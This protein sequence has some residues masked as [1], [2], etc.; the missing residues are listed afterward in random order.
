IVSQFARGL[1]AIDSPRER[2]SIAELYLVAGRRAKASS[3]YASARVYF[4]TGRMLLD[5]DSWAR[6]Y[7]LTFDLELNGAECDIVAGEWAA[8]EERLAG[9]AQ[10]VTT[11]ADQ[12]PVVCLSVLM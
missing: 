9:L 6:C 7:Q 1:S 8:A 2:E 11:L 4:A 5:E 3:A 12:V 10:H